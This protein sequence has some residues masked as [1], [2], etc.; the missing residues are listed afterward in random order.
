VYEEKVFPHVYKLP[1]AGDDFR[2]ILMLLKFDVR[3]LAATKTAIPPRKA[4]ESNGT[5]ESSNGDGTSDEPIWRSTSPVSWRF[6][7]DK[8]TRQPFRRI[9]DRPQAA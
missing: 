9:H 5:N 1:G 6:Y 3:S 4:F 2:P 8:P 7:Y